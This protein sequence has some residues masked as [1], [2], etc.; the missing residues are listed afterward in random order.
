MNYEL[1][2]GQ[3][4]AIGGQHSWQDDEL[5]NEE[6]GKN[7]EKLCERNACSRKLKEPRGRDLS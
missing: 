3:C 7:P 5:S 4:T 6:Q 1:S 2:S